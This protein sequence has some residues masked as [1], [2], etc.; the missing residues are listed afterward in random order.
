M[1]VVAASDASIQFGHLDAS[2]AAIR[3]S[4]VDFLAYRRVA[5]RTGL[6]KI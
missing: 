4:K 6:I 5:T 1:M 2:G 3:E